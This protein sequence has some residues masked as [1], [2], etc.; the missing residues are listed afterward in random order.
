MQT[1]AK[2]RALQ[3]KNQSSEMSSLSTCPMGFAMHRSAEASAPVETAPVEPAEPAEPAEQAE[4][5]QLGEAFIPEQDAPT[6][7]E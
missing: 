2:Q 1:G 5:A 6:S 3:C 7:E 4:N